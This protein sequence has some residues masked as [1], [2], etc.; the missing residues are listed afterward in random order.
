MPIERLEAE[1]NVSSDSPRDITG[2]DARDIAGDATGD[3]T[4]DKGDISEAVIVLTRHIERLEAELATAVTDRDASRMQAAQVDILNA[5]LEIERTRL[6]EARQEADR[7][8]ELA[9]A[10]RG[11]WAWLRRPA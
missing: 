4:S 6:T 7:W 9:T 11:L 1:R 3:V 5:V 10:P 2:D 8:R